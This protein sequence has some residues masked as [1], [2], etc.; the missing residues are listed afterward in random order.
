M[1][2]QLRNDHH[3]VRFESCQSSYG[4]GIA[5]DSLHYTRLFKSQAYYLSYCSY[6]CAGADYLVNRE[7]VCMVANVVCLVCVA[8]AWLSTDCIPRTCLLSSVLCDLPR[9]HDVMQF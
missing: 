2:W 5:V 9:C 3:I 7:P 4:R 1:R 8:V 6:R